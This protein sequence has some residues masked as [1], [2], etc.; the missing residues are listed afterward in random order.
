MPFPH[1]TGYLVLGQPEL[2]EQA[3]RSMELK[4]DLPQ[5]IDPRFSLGITVADWTLPEY[6]WARRGRLHS[7]SNSIALVAAQ[8]SQA[9]LGV[10]A[11]N[12][13]IAVI[14]KLM[15][16]NPGAAALGFVFGLADV[17]PAIG[18]AGLAN[19][20]RDTRGYDSSSGLLQQSGNNV[21]TLNTSNAAHSV[22]IQAGDTMVLDIPFVLTNKLNAAGRVPYFFLQSTLAQPLMY[23]VSWRERA[24][25]DSER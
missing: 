12:P 5:L 7:I 15:I 1:E 6:W 14:E 18:F 8:F 25:L 11:A 16:S 23:S 20:Q 17:A 13:T 2:A 3:M 21:A 22:F 9:V 4:G 10:P 24:L 19:G